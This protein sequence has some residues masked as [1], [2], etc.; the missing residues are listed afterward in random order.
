MR[1]PSTA[2]PSRVSTL[3]A[4]VALAGAV[5]SGCT[6]RRDAPAQA[7]QTA[8]VTTSVV[9]I[10]AT[11]EA[12]AT[13]AATG[14]L[15]SV[16][17]SRCGDPPAA[18]ELA[19]GQLPV[20]VR[21]C[22]LPAELGV[23]VILD[24]RGRAAQNGDTLIV[25]YAGIRAADGELFDASYMRGVPFDFVLGRGGVIAGWDAGL[26]GSKAGGVVQLDVPADMAYGDS[27]P[28]DGAI[29]PGDALTFLI[30]VRAVVPPT[31]AADAPL[32]LMG[33]KSIGATSVMWTDVHVGDGALVTPGSTAV[34]HLL[35][36]RG[37]TMK[38]LLNTWERSDP[39]QILMS[40]DQTLPGLV[41]G[42]QGAAV[43]GVRR[44]ALPPD[45]AYGPGGAPDLGLPA[46][47]DLIV[48]AEV[49]GVY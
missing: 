8:A 30:E 3:V 31:S 29:R 40:D 20:V 23:H 12:V 14:S 13:T 1:S 38:V 6:E 10:V 47:T 49:L 17:P 36:A 33:E 44:I 48:V 18:G 5:A 43:G 19:P 16:D 25:D 22:A 2:A 42:L 4:A 37:D 15:P 45:Q 7:E 24:G 28:G 26:V 46:G 32:D 34:V 41:E 11:T 27:P 9:A 21:P 35:L 39:L